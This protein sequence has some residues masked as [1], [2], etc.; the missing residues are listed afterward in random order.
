MVKTLQ[1]Q[2]AEGIS[3]MLGSTSPEIKV[4]LTT[5]GRVEKHGDKFKA[6]AKLSD[7]T[8]TKLVDKHIGDYDTYDHAAE[9][10]LRM[11]NTEFLAIP[12]SRKS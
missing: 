10:V 11:H 1:E 2:I 9:I 5:V 6:I 12:Q 3:N 8:G 4:G 7:E